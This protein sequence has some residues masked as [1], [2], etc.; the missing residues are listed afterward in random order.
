M[1]KARAISKGLEKENEALANEELR[2]PGTL[3]P[4]LPLGSGGSTP[5]SES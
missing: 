3:A 1:R 4:N 5:P 2:D